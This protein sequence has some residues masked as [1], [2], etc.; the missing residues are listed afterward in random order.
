MFFQVARVKKKKWKMNECP[1]MSET[2]Y[3]AFVAI[4][5]ETTC[6]HSDC[7]LWRR[8]GFG[9]N[10]NFWVCLMFS[11]CQDANSCSTPAE[12]IMFFPQ[13]VCS[14][15]GVLTVGVKAGRWSG[16]SICWPVFS[17]KLS[18]KTVFVTCPWAFRLRA[19]A[20][21]LRC[22]FSLILVCGISFEHFCIKLFFRRPSARGLRRLA[23]PVFGLQHLT[24]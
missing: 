3:N 21:S 2:N 23:V 22:E 7:C 5:C 13:S 11:A 24:W 15:W 19:L 12:I 1:R 8:F 14:H 4:G 20:Q 10:L 17:G 6:Q 9:L 16:C 18:R